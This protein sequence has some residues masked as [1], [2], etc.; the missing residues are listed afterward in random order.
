MQLE[1]LLT[2]RQSRQTQ[3]S[4]HAPSINRQ[5]LL[6]L[7]LGL[8]VLLILHITGGEQ[9]PRTSQMGFGRDHRLELDDRFFC[10]ALPTLDHSAVVGSLLIPLRLH[11][12]D[13]ALCL[14]PIAG[15]RGQRE[16]QFQNRD[17]FGELLAQFLNIPVG[18]R[19]V[20]RIAPGNLMLCQKT[21]FWIFDPI[22]ELLFNFIFLFRIGFLHDL[23]P[24]GELFL[25]WIGLAHRVQMLEGFL[26]SILPK[27]E[28]QQSRPRL[29]PKWFGFDHTP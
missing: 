15:L 1:I 9:Q 27:Q 4:R 24:L 5:D 19:C 2:R 28:C 14:V 7:F 22:G 29:H 13:D 20:P 8:D 11:R 25:I 6:V 21:V 18:L 26:L 12:L 23:F 3:Y 10:L 17:V 16:P